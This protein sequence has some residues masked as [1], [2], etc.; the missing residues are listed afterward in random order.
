MLTRMAQSG[1]Y[2]T[3]QLRSK[4]ILP[5]RILLCGVCV[6]PIAQRREVSS[7]AQ[8]S[9]S[10]T[11]PTKAALQRCFMTFEIPTFLN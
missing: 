6:S 7:F 1:S 5:L 2:Y 8:A 3:P 10:C 9:F 4:S 11:T